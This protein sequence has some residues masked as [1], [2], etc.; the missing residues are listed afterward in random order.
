M[1]KVNTAASDTYA[2]ML[3]WS[4]PDRLLFTTRRQANNQHAADL[5]VVK[6]RH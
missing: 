4:S 5:Y 1:T 2:P 3:D 6:Y